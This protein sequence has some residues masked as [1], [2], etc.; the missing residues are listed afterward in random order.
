MPTVT[1][2]FLR[3]SKKSFSLCS[4]FVRSL[5]DW[6]LRPVLGR[7]LSLPQSTAIITYP[8][9][10]YSSLRNKKPSAQNWSVGG[11]SRA[12]LALPLFRSCRN[13][14]VPVLPEKRSPQIWVVAAKKGGNQNPPS[15]AIRLLSP[16][17]VFVMVLY[18]LADSDQLLLL[19]YPVIIMPDMGQRPISENTPL[20]S[21]VPA[22]P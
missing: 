15:A 20:K 22:I 6:V 7:V 16:A 17:L 13:F 11:F 2:L 3:W 10:L 4:L 14:A 9:A 19:F 8:P 21:P 18:D 12:S 5:F 1:P